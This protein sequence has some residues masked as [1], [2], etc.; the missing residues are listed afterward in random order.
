MEHFFIFIE[1]KKSTADCGL[2]GTGRGIY[3]YY[4]GYFIAI[5]SYSM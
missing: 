1:L 4:G 3:G 5:P 2:R